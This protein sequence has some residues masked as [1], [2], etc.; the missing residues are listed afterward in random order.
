ML[1]ILRRVMTQFLELYRERPWVETCVKLR[2]SLEWVAFSLIRQK[3]KLY[4][5]YTNLWP[6]EE[7]LYC[8]KNL[9]LWRILI[10]SY[11]PLGLWQKNILMKRFLWRRITF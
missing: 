1:D 11:I 10:I 2:E 9:S 7:F 6:I 5:F 8:Q 4:K 3:K